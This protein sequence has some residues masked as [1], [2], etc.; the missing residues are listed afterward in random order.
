[1]LDRDSTQ[2]TVREYSINSNRRRTPAAVLAPGLLSYSQLLAAFWPFSSMALWRSL[3]LV[4]SIVQVQSDVYLHNPRGSNNKLSEQQNN[5]QNQNRLFDSQNNAAGGYQIGDA[6]QPVCQ[7][8][9]RD[10][11][12]TKEGAMKGTLTY[13]H[14]SEL[15][16][17]WVVQHGC[18]VDQP[19]IICQMILQYMCENDN[20]GLRDGT[21]RGNENTAGGEEEPPTELDAAEPA[22][23]QHEPLQFY[24]D[25]KTSGCPG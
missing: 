3:C 19:N 20:P 13:Y 17:E 9:D 14:G 1:M 4:V 6:C 12:E 18:G 21:K 8:E 25:C 22:L 11:D 10:Y 16:I 7:N 23:G 5:A 24:L 2:I 15:Y